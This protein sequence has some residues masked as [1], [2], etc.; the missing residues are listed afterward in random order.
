MLTNLK[1]IKKSL[2][3]LQTI[4][5]MEEDGTLGNYGKKE[6]SMLRREAARMH[7]NLDGIFDGHRTFLTNRY[8]NAAISKLLR[9]RQVRFI[10][11]T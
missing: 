4:E 8:E 5:K 1:T 2:K 6:Q 10:V 11:A 3:R 9:K 7:R